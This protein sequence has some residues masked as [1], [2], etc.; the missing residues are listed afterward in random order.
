MEQAKLPELLREVTRRIV[1]VSDPERII[2]FGSY[3]RGDFGPNSDLDLLVIKDPVDS[4]SAEAR[5]IYQ[6]LYGIDIP[7]DVVVVRTS[8]VERYG[9]LVDTI[10]RSALNEG[11]ELYGRR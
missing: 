9:N 8:Y 11:K 7:I 4:T 3:A 6:A 2:L 1:E 10:V 5:R